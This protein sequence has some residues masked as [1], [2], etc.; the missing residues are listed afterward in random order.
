MP[1]PKSSGSG[2]ADYGFPGATAE[3]IGFR[4]STYSCGSP[5]AACVNS[6]SDF[7]A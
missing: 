3:G 5:E 1:G 2:F 6:L 7:V 4:P